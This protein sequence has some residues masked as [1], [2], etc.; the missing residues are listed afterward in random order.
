MS[1]SSVNVDDGGS[2]I[3]DNYFFKGMRKNASRK[4]KFFFILLTLGDVM[5]DTDKKE[6]TF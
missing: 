3:G 6:M 5:N 4:F 2:A 1:E